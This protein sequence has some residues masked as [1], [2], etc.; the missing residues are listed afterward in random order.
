MRPDSPDFSDWNVILFPPNLKGR[1]VEHSLSVLLPVRNNQDTLSATVTEI[2]E[3]LPELTSRFELVIIDDGSTD[4]T[5]E[6]AD[7]LSAR[8]PQVLLA[9]HGETKGSAEAL[10]TGLKRSRGEIIF[11]RDENCGLAVNEIHKLWKAVKDHPLVLGR[12]Q[13]S[14][15]S[16]WRQWAHPSEGAGFKMLHRHAIEEVETSLTDQSSIVEDL[17]RR[18]YRWHEVQMRER[19]HSRRSRLG[20]ARPRQRGAMKSGSSD[21]R[22]PNYLSRLKDFAIGE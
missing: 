10:R 9:T 15:W 16:K 1:L 21:P 14:S 6:I 11:I 13:Q 22:R 3:V 4:A 5:V 17:L 8:F 12:A 19:L 7:E 20:V 2:L 18:G